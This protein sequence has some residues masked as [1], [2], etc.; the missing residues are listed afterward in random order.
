VNV[1]K[2]ENIFGLSPDPN[3]KPMFFWAKRLTQSKTFLS[4][5][6]RYN[7]CAYA[8]VRIEV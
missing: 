8:F 4:R 7:I 1:I 5:I 2:D 3:L 6:G